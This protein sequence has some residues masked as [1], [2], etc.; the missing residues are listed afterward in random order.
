MQGEP[1]WEKRLETAVREAEAA[2]K[3]IL[4]SFIDPRCPVCRQ[5]E[6]DTFADE[7]TVDFLRNNFITVQWTITG[8]AGLPAEFIVSGTPS[9]IVIDSS[10]E[11]YCCARGYLSPEDFISFLIL[12]IAKM[13]FAL[14]NINSAS[15]IL[16]RVIADCPEGVSI[17]EA[18]YY[19]GLCK[20]MHT[21]SVDAMK[22]AYSL[23]LSRFPAS[24]WT[25]RASAYKTL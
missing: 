15:I 9:F 3:P 8:E 7:R 5:M 4:L 14:G 16:E 1:L 10:K 24:R 22:E 18:I 6:V 17:P 20:Y 13:H 19:R 12:A 2:Q 23:L 25:Q 11:A 21:K